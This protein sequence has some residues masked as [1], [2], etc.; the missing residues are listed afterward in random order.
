MASLVTAW[1]RAAAAPL[2]A[3]LSCLQETRFGPYSSPLAAGTHDDKRGGFKQHRF[4]ILQSWRSEAQ[5]GFTELS[6]LYGS[7][8]LGSPF[9]TPV[10]P[11]ALTGAR[12][13]C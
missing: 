9:P 13:F 10:T 2:P 6:R 3:S 1:T 4:F 7:E 5:F 12:N 8:G 11:T